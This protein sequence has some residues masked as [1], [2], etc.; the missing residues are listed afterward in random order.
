MEHKQKLTGMGTKLFLFLSLFLLSF[1]S[2]LLLSPSVERKKR[3]HNR[4][5]GNNFEGKNVKKKNRLRVIK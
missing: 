4:N 3:N 5:E 1:R 2:F